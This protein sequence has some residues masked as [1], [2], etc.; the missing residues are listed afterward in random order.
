MDYITGMPEQSRLFAYAFGF[1]FLLGIL[2]DVFRVVRMALSL[3]KRAV[4]VQDILYVLLCGILT[5]LY[6]LVM[7]GG[8]LKGYLLAG[9]L[10]GWLVYYFSMGVVAIRAS[11][12]VLRAIRAVAR[13]VKSLFVRPVLFFVL[14]IRKIYA[15]FMKKMR[16]NRAKA[17]KK[18]KY[19]LKTRRTMM[20]NLTDVVSLDDNSNR[21]NKKSGK[22]KVKKKNK[23]A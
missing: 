22:Q 4:F 18:T 2:Y 8:Q 3:Q 9:Q 17:I 15:F 11:E 19:H 1:G 23:K 12:A 21:E 6:A 14:R 5:F 13:F 16:I 20:Y 10:L 7:Q